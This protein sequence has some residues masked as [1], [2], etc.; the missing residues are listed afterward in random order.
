MICCYN[1]HNYGYYQ[2]LL[3]KTQ[4]FGDWIL[5][6]SSGATYSVGRNPELGT[7]FI[8]WV[9][10]NRYHLKT[11]TESRIRNDVFQIKD[12]TVDKV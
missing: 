2:C 6:P 12:R 9:Q 1:Y 11:E 3:I 7:S 5:S 10:L 8:D 4:R